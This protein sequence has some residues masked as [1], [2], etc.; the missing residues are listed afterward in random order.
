MIE[1]SICNSYKVE[2][3]QGIHRKDHIYKIALFTSEAVLNKDTKTYNKQPHEVENGRGYETR[4]QTLLGFLVI[5]DENVACLSFKNPVW[6][7]ATIKARGALIY[8]SSILG[9]NSVCVLDFGEDIYSTNDDFKV[10][11]P[12]Q[13]APTALVR[14][15]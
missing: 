10:L 12:L 11:F 6:P 8:N 4:G 14:I 13:K 9:A 5:L 7:R 15:R 2:V 3:L 1:Q